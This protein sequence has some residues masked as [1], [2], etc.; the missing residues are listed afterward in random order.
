MIGRTTKEI[1]FAIPRFVHCA[2]PS[3][4]MLLSA[5]PQ[6]PDRIALTVIYA[7]A[8]YGTSVRNPTHFRYKTTGFS[9]TLW[10]TL[11]PG[12]VPPLLAQLGPLHAWSCALP[13]TEQRL[14]GRFGR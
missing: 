7:M 5:S 10:P 13:R 14:Y 8:L 6:W 2:E 9:S 1:R 4:V 12:P 11:P 3:T